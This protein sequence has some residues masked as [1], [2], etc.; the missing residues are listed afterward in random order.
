MP[1]GPKDQPSGTDDLPARARR[2]FKAAAN[3]AY[4]KHGDDAEERAH[5]TA[6]AAVKNAGYHKN[7]EGKWVSSDSIR[8]WDPSQ[9]RDPDGKWSG[10][11]GGG[12]GGSA[13][14]KGGG[15]S[16]G[17]K[18]GGPKE[19]ARGS[20][21]GHGYS[22]NA[23]VTGGVIKTTNVDDAVRAVFEN[24]KVELKQPRQVAVAIDRL[25]KIAS[26]M[27]ALGSAAPNFNLCNVSV[28]GTNL[29]CAETKGIPRIKMPQLKDAKG[30]RKHLEKELGL[31][32]TK[33]KEYASHLKAT[34]N[35][36]VGAKVAAM[37]AAIRSGKLD[38]DDTD[39]LFVSRDNY[40]V[41][42]HHRWAAMIG[43]D[44]D[45]NVLG[46]ENKM[47][48][49][50][51]DMDII[52]LLKEAQKFSG[53]AKG[54]NDRRRRRLTVQRDPMGR[55]VGTFEEEDFEDKMRGPLV[56]I[57]D[58][59]GERHMMFDKVELADAH[60]QFT[61]DGYL[62][63]MPRIARTG[64]Q[65]YTGDECSRPQMDEVRIYRPAEEVFKNDAW[66]TYTHLPITVDHPS[67]PVTAA[68]WKKYAVGETGEEV[69]RDGT[70]GRVPMMLRDSAAIQSYKDGKKQLSVGYDCDLDWTPGVTDSGE[71]YDAVQRNIRA[72]HLAVVAAARGGPTLI[73]G[74]EDHTP[75]ENAMN[76]KTI[77]VDGIEVRVE[78]TAATIVQ[79]TLNGLQ[80]QVE[81]FKK[82]FKQ[83]EEDDE[84]TEK[85]LAKKDA[86][87]KERDEAIKAKDAE[88]ATLKKQVTDA[89]AEISP[90][91]QDARVIDRLSV[92]SRAKA[93]LGDKWVSGGKSTAEI[94]KEVVAGKVG[95][96]AKGWDDHQVEA[97]F[98]SLQVPTFSQNRDQGGPQQRSPID[99]AITAFGRPGQGYTT[100]QDERAKAYDGYDKDVSEAWRGKTN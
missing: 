24:H 10:G 23:V 28:S 88:I 100:I 42:G 48:I 70:A 94:R 90:E 25:G 32:V 73:I 33:E 80:D 12:G 71:R 22:E 13:S 14:G 87:I 21:I 50:R 75:K 55:E 19:G 1:Y 7:K 49:L 97:A 43:T 57:V 98:H 74:D 37:A 36:L 81:N 76:V 46:D 67:E 96:V 40:I 3:S 64:I 29:F 31:D 20:E 44:A 79:R 99:D 5:R 16:G 52:P 45:N 86:A 89:Q 66:K 34:Q 41:D 58:S 77:L 35:E 72:N 2:I 84:E 60:V 17:G 93:F 15:T 27:I 91:K 61:G 51:V 18:G 83:S 95:D 53:A 54:V 39:R 56:E 65:I 9:P 26:K 38:P 62:K 63:A 47:R 30:F 69:L 11:G 92:I 8:D 6:W 68:N 85:E 59:T 4:S 82:R 78:D